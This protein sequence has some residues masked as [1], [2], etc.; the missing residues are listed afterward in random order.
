[1][2][3]PTSEGAPLRAELEAAVV[4]QLLAAW[5]DLNYSH[6]RDAMLPPAL[7]LS[8]G[9]GHLGRWIREHRCIEISRALVLEQP[10]GVVLEVL[11]RYPSV[12]M[13]KLAVQASRSPELKDEAQQAVMAIAQNLAGKGIDVREQLS[14][15]GLEPVKLEII[16]AQY[17]AGSTQKDVTSVVQKYAGNLPLVSL[18]SNYNAAFGNP[19][20]GSTKQLK[21][22][23]RMNGKAGEATFAENAPILLPLPR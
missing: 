22:Q 18:P 1:M 4:R 23:Y 6:F 2:L 21:V 15:A 12:E 20:P 3:D 16:K 8:E 11:K 7:A 5:R 9:A 14:Q 19:A 10:W 13:L 17:G